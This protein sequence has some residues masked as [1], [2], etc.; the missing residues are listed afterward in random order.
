MSLGRW[1]CQI[2]LML[3]AFSATT[4][5]A[6]VYRQHSVADHVSRVVGREAVDCGQFRRERFQSLTLSSSE[7]ATVRAC[8]A[9][10][11]SGGKPFF[12]WIERPGTDSLFATGL[13]SARSGGL[14]RFHYDSAPCG[15]PMC[16]SRFTVHECP[17]LEHREIIDPEERCEGGPTKG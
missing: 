1:A 13:V 2:G 3:V 16:G 4:A 14:Q 10:A 8:M 9:A 11:R 12:F 5:C 15:G 17:G 6:L 7:A